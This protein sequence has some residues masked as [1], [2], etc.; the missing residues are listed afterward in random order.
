M[1]ICWKLERSLDFVVRPSQRPSDAS[2]CVVRGRGARHARPGKYA[3]VNGS[4]CDTIP[5]PSTFSAQ[6]DG[7]H[8]R[9]L[10]LRSP[11]ASR[12]GITATEEAIA[13]RSAAEELCSFLWRVVSLHAIFSMCAA[14]RWSRLL[15]YR[16]PLLTSKSNSH[17]EGTFFLISPH[18]SGRRNTI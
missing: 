5:L 8:V 7:S 12:I 3:I 14:R 1:L 2:D 4:Q 15:P 9:I 17:H 16:A 6:R 10:L 11:V 18:C 13:F